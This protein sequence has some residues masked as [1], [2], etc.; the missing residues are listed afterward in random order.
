MKQLLLALVV[1]VAVGALG[2]DTRP[3][4]RLVAPATNTVSDPSNSG[5]DGDGTVVKSQKGDPD[6]TGDHAGD[7]TADD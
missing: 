2:C 7:P 5:A 3:N 1:V 6:V 4:Q